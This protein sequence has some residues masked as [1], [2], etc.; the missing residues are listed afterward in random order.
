MVHAVTQITEGKPTAAR[1]FQAGL[2]D[3]TLGDSRSVTDR[4]GTLLELNLPIARLRRR[5]VQ[6][7][8][9]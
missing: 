7:G 8:L 4:F 5:T 6:G 3:Q 1:H 2:F 9:G